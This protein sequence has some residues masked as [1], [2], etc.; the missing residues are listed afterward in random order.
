MRRL[1]LL[2]TQLFNFLRMRIKVL[3]LTL[4]VASTN[5]LFA[6][7][8]QELSGRNTLNVI[9]TSVPFLMIAPDSRAGAMGDAGVSSSP[10]VFSMHWNPAK[11]AVF[12][13]DSVYQVKV[14]KDVKK[15]AE[16]I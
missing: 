15:Y 14:E 3:L 7:T 10:D 16:Q 1:A 6:Q 5:L 2:N 8:Y 4:L 13:N 12:F 11:Y 9:T